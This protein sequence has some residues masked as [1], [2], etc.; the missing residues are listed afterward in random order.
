LAGVLL[1]L[2][3]GPLGLVFGL[4]GLLLAAHYNGSAHP[5]DTL[6]GK[7][8]ALLAGAIIGAVLRLG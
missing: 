1:A 4:G 6:R 8:A 3:A 5:L 7:T 2:L